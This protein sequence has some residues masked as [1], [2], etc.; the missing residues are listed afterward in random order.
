M[1]LTS[2]AKDLN[3]FWKNNQIAIKDKKSDQLVLQNKGLDRQ[4]LWRSISL[5]QKMLKSIIQLQDS[6]NI[7]EDNIEAIDK[8]LKIVDFILE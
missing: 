8:N 6:Q 3:I 2:S 4:K 7:N 1:A 5:N